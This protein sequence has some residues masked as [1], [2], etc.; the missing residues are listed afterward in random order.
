M[1]RFQEVTRKAP[2]VCIGRCSPSQKLEV[3][4]LL[5]TTTGEDRLVAAVGDGTNDIGMLSEADVG[6]AIHKS[7]SST[8]SQTSLRA[9][10]SL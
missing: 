8:P 4:K 1:E 9:D 3:A 6:V 7:N 5:R 2:A 10:F